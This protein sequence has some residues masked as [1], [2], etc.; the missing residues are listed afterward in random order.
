M[1]HLAAMHSN[2][3]PR[4]PPDA[5]ELRRL[6]KQCDKGYVAKESE[7]ANFGFVDAPYTPKKDRYGE[8]EDYFRSL[9]TRPPPTPDFWHVVRRQREDAIN[10]KGL[11]LLK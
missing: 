3:R 7:A 8:P 5:E 2:E 10:P 6:M 9:P 1:G 11:A 4:P